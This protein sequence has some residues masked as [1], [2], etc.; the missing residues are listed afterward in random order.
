MCACVLF[1]APGI[2]ARQ[3]AQESVGF[4]IGGRRVVFGPKRTARETDHR[5]IL[6]YRSFAVDGRFIAYAHR[7]Y[8]APNGW[9]VY[10]VC[11]PQERAFGG[12]TVR[13]GGWRRYE[14]AAQ[15]DGPVEAPGLHP[16]FSTPAFVGRLMAYWALEEDGT[17]AAVVYHLVSD[18][19]VRRRVLGRDLAPRDVPYPMPTA[20][21]TDTYTMFT[22][23]PRDE[24]S[25]GSTLRKTVVRIERSVKLR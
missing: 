20:K 8:R 11:T 21:I 1:G 5:V 2:G 15:R 6:D 10:Q 14:V 24:L 9:I 22:F 25:T 7:Y 19:I 17:V 3:A 13:L 4:T 16:Y 18:T 12:D 23:D